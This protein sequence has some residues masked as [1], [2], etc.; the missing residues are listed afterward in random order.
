MTT[1][2]KT[3]AGRLRALG[4][5]IGLLCGAEVDYDDAAEAAAYYRAADWVI[6]QIVATPAED[7]E[8]MVVKARAVA[9]CCASRTNF[10]LG[11]TSAERV[12]TVLLTDL[13][14]LDPG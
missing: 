4:V 11:Q 9:W 8:G 12:M 13:L 2:T 6:D 3:N 7:L 14:A 5:T 10:A 1:N